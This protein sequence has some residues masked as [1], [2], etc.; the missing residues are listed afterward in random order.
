MYLFRGFVKKTLPQA[1][2]IWPYDPKSP[3]PA[4]KK[5]A[6]LLLLQERK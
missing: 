3:L 2:Q 5:Q 6:T 4:L 1:D